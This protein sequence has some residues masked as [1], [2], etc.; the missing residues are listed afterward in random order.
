MTG[1]ALELE[2][3]NDAVRSDDIVVDAVERELISF[4]VALDEPPQPA[5]PRIATVCLLAAAAG[6]LPA[7]LFHDYGGTLFLVGW[8]F[9]FWFIAFRWLLPGSGPAL[10]SA[11]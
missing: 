8:L 11:A 6:Y 1:H 7:V 10:E 4:L 2:C 5:R 3:R 9:I